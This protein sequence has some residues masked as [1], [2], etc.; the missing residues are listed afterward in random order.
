[1]LLLIKIVNMLMFLMTVL[2]IIIT[3]KSH[4]LH[5]LNF[6]SRHAPDNDQS[7]RKVKTFKCKHDVAKIFSIFS[8]RIKLRFCNVLQQYL[9]FNCNKIL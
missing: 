4:K 1:M 6:V 9:K 8:S 5:R 3:L 7:I 2:K